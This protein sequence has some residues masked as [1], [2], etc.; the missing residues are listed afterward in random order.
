MMTTQTKTCS[1]FMLSIM[2]LN[3]ESDRKN[4]KLI[5]TTIPMIFSKTK[6]KKNVC[7]E[8]EVAT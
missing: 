5:Q 3:K 2:K 7:K 8:R 6:D 1:N 4:N